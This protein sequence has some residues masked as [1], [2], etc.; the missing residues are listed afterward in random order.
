MEKTSPDQPIYAGI[1]TFM[2][3]PY[4]PKIAD[5][6]GY[7]V[8]VIGLPIDYGAS[9]REGA[10]HAPRSIRAHSHWEDLDGGEFFDSDTGGIV[11]AQSLSIADV[12]DVTVY[13]TDAKRTNE[14][15]IRAVSELRKKAFPLI[16]GGD[17]SITYASF[18]GCHAALSEAEKPMGLLHFDA[19]LDVEKSYGVMPEVWHGNPFRTLIDEGLLEGENMVTIGPRG[20]I[21]KKWIDY[22]REKGIHLFTTPDIRRQGIDKVIEQAIAHLRA[23]CKSVYLTFDIDCIDPAQAPGTGTPWVGGLKAEEVIPVMRQLSEVPVKA[24]D[25][26]EVNPPLDASGQTAILASDI[27][28][29]YLSFSLSKKS[30]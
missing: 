7:D 5:L 13:P 11:T 29:N 26:V 18:K 23:K 10:K 19:H 9:Y 30:K 8:G 21:A 2:R 20:L 17:H 4:V 27:I 6:H 15:I 14:E 3:S 28:W 1:N 16:L 22:V 24:F 25:M 12:G